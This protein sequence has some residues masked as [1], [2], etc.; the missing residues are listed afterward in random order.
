MMIDFLGSHMI[1]Q[2]NNSTCTSNTVDEP[3][4]NISWAYCHSDW[5]EKQIKKHKKKEGRKE[6]R[7]SLSLYFFEPNDRGESKPLGS[8]G[9]SFVGRKHTQQHRGVL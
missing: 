8:V 3:V 2:A 6:G 4:E 5:V 1:G 7:I 9:R